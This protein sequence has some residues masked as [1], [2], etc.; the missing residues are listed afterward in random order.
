MTENDRIDRLIR[1]RLAGLD[2]FGELFYGLSRILPRS[3]YIVSMG[4]R[5]QP[6]LEVSWQSLQGEG[7]I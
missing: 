1:M 6:L 2:F 7:L 5:Y 4:I 3:R